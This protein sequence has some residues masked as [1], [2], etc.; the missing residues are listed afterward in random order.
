MAAVLVALVGLVGIHDQLA[1][2][3]NE[4]HNLWA[5]PEMPSNG[6]PVDYKAAAAVI[7]AN[8]RPGDAIAFQTSD[9]NHY[10]V[11]TAM[12]YY[13]GSKLP[14][15]VFQAQTQVQANSL[16]PIECVDP[17]RL[18]NGDAAYLG[19]L[20]RPPGPG[21]VLGAAMVGRGLAPDPRLPDA[22][23]YGRRTESVSPC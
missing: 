9:E 4:A 20:R 7:A 1:I 21:P 23:G 11:D 18:H 3:Q 10:Q 13:L 2:R 6:T 12:E 22:G 17:S 8:E 5:Y 15:P 16:Q 14:T 19:G